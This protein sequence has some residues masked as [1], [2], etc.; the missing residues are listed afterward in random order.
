M[1]IGQP[2]NVN[3]THQNTW[4]NSLYNQLSLFPTESVPLLLSNNNKSHN[5]GDDVWVSEN[6]KDSFNV[7]SIPYLGCDYE[8]FAE[9]RM[10]GLGREPS[11]DDILIEE[12]PIIYKFLKNNQ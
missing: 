7:M 6:L 10:L 11:D 4:G 1:N 5:K 2:V 12:D 8:Q 3:T 9:W